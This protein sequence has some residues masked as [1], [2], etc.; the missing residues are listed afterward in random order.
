MALLKRV[1]AVSVCLALSRLMLLC[2]PPDAPQHAGQVNALIPSATR[3]AQTLK[4]RDGIDWNDL[5]KTEHSGRLRAGLVDGSILSLGSDSELRVVQHDAASQQTSIE[6]SYGKVRN[7]VVKIT[8]P[9]GKFEVKTPNA[10]IGVVGTDFYVGYAPNRTTVICYKGVVTVTPLGGAHATKSPDQS[11]QTASSNNAIT[12]SAGQMVEITTEIPAEGFQLRPVQPSAEQ[13]SMRDT[14][15]RDT[16]DLPVVRTHL[17]RNIILG[18]GL[19]ATGWAVGITQLHT[20]AP[21]PPPQPPQIIK[22]PP[23]SPKCG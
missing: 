12:V 7:R 6:M 16:P 22:C 13:A 9:S 18:V 1:T 11:G 4:V 3:N 15:V 2:A 14:D 8:Q 19:A 20:G 10:V 21:P 23:N 17:V 5:L